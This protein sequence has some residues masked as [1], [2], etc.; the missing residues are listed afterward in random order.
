MLM[1]KGFEQ[2]T[3]FSFDDII[4]EMKEKF[5]LVLQMLCAMSINPTSCSRSKIEQLIP[6]WGLVYGIVMQG[7]FQ[8]LSYV[9]HMLTAVMEESLCDQKVLFM[10]I[11]CI[12]YVVT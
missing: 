3:Q 5:H 12:H 9:Q 7:N 2:L 8:E 11:A 6:R 1:K 10:K 4:F